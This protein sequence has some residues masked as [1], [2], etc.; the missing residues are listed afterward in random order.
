MDKKVLVAGGCSHTQGSAFTKTV[1][2][3][4]LEWKNDK[5]AQLYPV[6]CTSDYIT[7]NLTWMGKIK[8]KLGIEEVYNFGFGGLGTLSTIDK[9]WNYCD[10]VEDLSDH[11][12]VLQ[13]QS[14][15]RNQV[16]YH[17]EKGLKIDT[18]RHLLNSDHLELNTR[19]LYEHHFIDE[20]IEEYYYYRDLSKLQRYV[21]SRGASF[22]VIDLPW[23]RI[24][25]WDQNDIDKIEIINEEVNR[26]GFEKKLQK[27]K[28]VLELINS[29][30][31]IN[32][33]DIP[34]YGLKPEDNI[35]MHT[36]G[37]IEGDFHYTE[38]GNERLS[39]VI[40]DNIDN[41]LT[42]KI[43]KDQIYSE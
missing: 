39:N 1:L 11:L 27:E 19:M 5:I 30:N 36:A 23:W 10:K 3:E 33:K 28:K 14:I 24:A 16:Y 40:A 35:T 37:F 32:L 2:A 15:F 7:Q 9:I 34:D 21:E 6:E 29:L 41:I 31:I 8:G 20:D 17:S 12:F 4:K 38:E 25:Q 43:G 42:F 26:I 13:L 22:R 18:L